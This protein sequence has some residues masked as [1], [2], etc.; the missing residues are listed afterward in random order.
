MRTPVAL[1]FLL[2]A[3]CGNVTDPPATDGPSTPTPDAEVDADPGAPDARIDAAPGTP[4]AEPISCTANEF[5]ACDDAQTARSCNATGDGFVVDACGAPGCNATAGRCNECVPSEVACDGDVVES[6]GANGLPLPDETCQLACVAAPSAHCA[7]LSPKY[8]PDVCDALATEPSFTVGTTTTFDTN[9]ET[10][11][12]GGVVT[13]S[14][15][16]PIC[17]VRAGT[18]TISGQ[19]TVTGG[20]ALAL[21]ADDTL[22]V[23]SLIDVSANNTTDGPGGGRVSG[24]KANV[25]LGGGGAGFQ[26]QGANGGTA[27][28]GGG[29]AGGAAFD[30]LAVSALVG[31]AHP[32]G[33][34]LTIGVFGGGGGGALTLIS[35]RGTVNIANGATI[36]AGGGGGNAGFDA[37]LGGQLQVYGGGGGGSGGNVVIQGL[38][39]TVTGRLFANGGGGASGGA[40]EVSGMKGGD[41]LRSS[42][43]PA[44][45]GA[46]V[47]G[48]GPGGTG[49]LGAQLPTVGRARTSASGSGGGGG[50]GTGYFTIYV[51]A[52]VT[53][54]KSP[55]DISPPFSPDQTSVTR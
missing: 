50:G 32:A 2:V 40:S 51:P 12:T 43:T 55:A 8:L 6:C 5:I 17:V 18:I 14:G 38:D 34:T 1:A 33:P 25:D 41:A 36:D 29:A 3:A 7:Y 9:L 53:P 28:D 24:A 47:S 10:A 49:G 26:Q 42:T 23:S 45:G 31:G 22:T 39:V 37:I 46:A 16:S 4:D 54:T 30:P 11:C 13:Q 21:V 48:S 15:G 19:M 20:R 27:T 35:C 52:G 44:G